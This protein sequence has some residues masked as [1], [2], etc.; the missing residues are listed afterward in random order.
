MPTIK[1]SIAIKRPIEKVFAYDT[2]IKSWPKWFVIVS[3]AEQTS[4]EAF[5]VGTTFKITSRMMGITSKQMGKITQYEANKIYS[6]DVGT[7]FHV[8]HKY[9]QTREGTELTLEFDVK[10]S[11]FFKLFSSLIV[12]SMRKSLKKSLSNLKNILESQP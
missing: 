2:D 11:W 8:N 12:N 9:E 4:P 6:K 10:L 5:N 7:N 3:E 1:E